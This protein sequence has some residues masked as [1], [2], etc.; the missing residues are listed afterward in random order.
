MKVL[1]RE[2]GRA[3]RSMAIVQLPRLEGDEDHERDTGKIM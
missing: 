2:E 3:G 1:H